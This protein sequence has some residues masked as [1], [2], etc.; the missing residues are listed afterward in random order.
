MPGV[1]RAMIPRKQY[2]RC[3]WMLR[4]LSGVSM[5][6]CGCYKSWSALCS[7]GESHLDRRDRD[8]QAEAFAFVP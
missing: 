5:T 6:P 7:T 3:L 4:T 2:S 1:V 8:L